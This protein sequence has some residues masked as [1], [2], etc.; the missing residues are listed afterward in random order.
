MSGWFRKL[1]GGNA[2]APPIRKVE[3]IL[4]IPLPEDRP[5]PRFGDQPLRKIFMEDL[6][7]GEGVRVNPH[8][9]VIE[10][11]AEASIRSVTEVADRL[12]ALTAVAV[13]GEG[14]EQEY[15]ESFIEKRAIHPLLTP[16][17]RDFIA[18]KAPS[19][20]ERVQFSWRYEA[21][22]TLFWALGWTDGVL[23]LPRAIC[24]VSHLVATVRDNPDLT[25]HGRR[26]AN[27]ILNEADLIYRC[28]WAVVQASIDGELPSGGLDPGV[29][30]ERHHALNWLICYDN[31]DW[32]DVTTDT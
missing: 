7:R 2:P 19:Q 21:A 16:R 6:L 3:P 20:H 22:W 18:Q 32:D 29:T 1:M 9:P 10:S 17:E 27:D 30:M 13:K 25:I 4:S 24:D 11:E 14:L 28:H 5:G 15:V 26:S 12:L 31:A 23:G 8:L